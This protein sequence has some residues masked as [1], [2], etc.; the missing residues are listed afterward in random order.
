ML[1]SLRVLLSPSRAARRRVR[2]RRK[3]IRQFS[4]FRFTWL[5]AAL[6]KKP[7]DDQKEGVFALDI[8]RRV[9][10]CIAS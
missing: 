5:T 1:L 8:Q 9:C 4:K 6:E 7:M 2:R 10:V 3:R